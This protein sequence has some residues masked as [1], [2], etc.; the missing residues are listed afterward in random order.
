VLS[1]AMASGC[2]GALLR[3]GAVLRGA[4]PHVRRVS[5]GWILIW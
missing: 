3:F 1:A 4:D 2:E 5:S